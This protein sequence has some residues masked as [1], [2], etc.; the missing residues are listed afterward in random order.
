MFDRGQSWTTIVGIVSDVKQYGLDRESTD[1]M[2]SITLQVVA[3]KESEFPKL[4]EAYAKHV[5][6]SA[7][8]SPMAKKLFDR[9]KE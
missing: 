7:L 9:K 1:E 6:E 2:G 4:Q 3:A 8:N 5:R